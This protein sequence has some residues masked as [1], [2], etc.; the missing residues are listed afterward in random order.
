MEYRRLTGRSGPGAGRPA[1]LYRRPDSE[2]AVSIPE[3]RYDLTGELLA[4]AIE[5]SASADRPVRDVLPEMAYSAGREIGASSGSLEAALHN[6][7]FQ[8]R[9]DNCEGWVLG[10]CPFHQLAR[11][12]TQLICGLNL[13]LLRGVADGAGATGTRWC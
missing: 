1:K 13:Q 11:Q 2:V 7:G 5:E 10:N 8:P 3:R 12:H 6:Y 4:A 9:S